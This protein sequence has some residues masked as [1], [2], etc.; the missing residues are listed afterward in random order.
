MILPYLIVDLK[1]CNRTLQKAIDEIRE[2]FDF[3][4]I[5]KASS[6]SEGSRVIYRNK[7]IGGHAASQNKEDKNVS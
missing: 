5:Q 6:L 1:L 2:T 3:L 4:S 7:L